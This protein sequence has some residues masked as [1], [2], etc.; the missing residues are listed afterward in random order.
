MLIKLFISLFA[1]IV[2]ISSVVDVV[3]LKKDSNLT[4]NTVKFISITSYIQIVF[5]SI[6]IVG[7]FIHV[8]NKH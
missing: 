6:I 5:S 8:F 1:M 7:M 4:S 3:L 2:L